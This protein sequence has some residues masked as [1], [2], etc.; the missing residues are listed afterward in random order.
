MRIYNTL[1]MI[2][3]KGTIVDVH[4]HIGHFNHNGKIVNFTTE[5]L[6]KFTKESLDIAIQNGKQQDRVKKVMVSNLD[7]MLDNG[8][9]KNEMAGNIITLQAAKTN[10][11]IAPIAVCQP[12][13]TNGDVGIMKRLLDEND[14]KFVGLKFHPSML[15]LNADDKAYDKYLQLAEEKKLP[16]LFHSEVKIDWANPNSPKL[17][18]LE[19]T[20]DPR[21]I[22]ELAKRHPNT[23]VILG[24]TGMG[25]GPSHKYAIDT[26]IES[27]EKNNALLYADI[28]WMDW[29]D[30]HL[31]LNDKNNLFYFIDKLKEKGKLDRILFGSDAP[32]G[33]YGEELA[34]GLSEKQ[35]YEL[36]V[37]SLKSAIKNHFGDNAD[38]IIDKIFYKNADEL[39]F[40][41]NW[42]KDIP[43]KQKP[44]KTKLG[45]LIGS[46]IL[47]FSGITLLI[48]GK[49]KKN[50]DATD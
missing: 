43:L 42:A 32:L 5:T 49:K 24:H 28:S 31:P 20:S 40:E 18:E 41:K 12:N 4:G 22:Y 9:Y 23:P 1:N 19:C 13:I 34:G 6:D 29:G 26:I 47:A 3:F 8:T 36:T 27:I 33:C 10:P 39:F 35:A 44:S 37:S 30:N 21:R 17:K 7:C 25:A 48:S 46:G 38:E 15:K 16:C 14:G 2:T 50:H 45:I 11:S